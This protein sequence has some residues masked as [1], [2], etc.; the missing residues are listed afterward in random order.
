MPFAVKSHRAVDLGR[1]EG[2]SGMSE[3]WN[4]LVTETQAH[5]KTKD[6]LAEL[7]R[8]GDALVRRI[9]DV[10]DGKINSTALE[11]AVSGW[12]EAREE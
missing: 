3:E 5:I 6:K 10:I 11:K 7:E 1:L 2:G 12:M 8:A 4:E 9:Y